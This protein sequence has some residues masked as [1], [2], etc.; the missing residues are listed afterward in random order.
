MYKK[1]KQVKR[2]GI[3]LDNDKWRTDKNYRIFDYT[4]INTKGKF[5]LLS[6]QGYR[7]IKDALQDAKVMGIT[8]KRDFEL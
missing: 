3:I 1:R 2:V 8:I 7:T 5:E 4:K 6:Q